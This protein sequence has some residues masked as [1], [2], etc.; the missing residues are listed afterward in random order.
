MSP[1]QRLKAAELRELA[2]RELA[3]THPDMPVRARDYLLPAVVNTGSGRAY[4]Y[5]TEGLPSA[6]ELTAD[7]MSSDAGRG[8]LELLAER[9]ASG[10][11]EDD[12]EATLARL[13]DMPAARR[14][15]EARRLGL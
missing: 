7:L 6:A 11:A 2:D 10:T 14:M 15:A 12:R 4:I 8:M 5:G 3:R 1:E 13:A 9:G